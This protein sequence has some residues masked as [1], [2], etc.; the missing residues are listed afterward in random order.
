MRLTAGAVSGRPGDTARLR[1]LVC[2]IVHHPEDARILYRQIRAILDA[3]HSV[4]YAAPF[5]AYDIDPWPELQA[6]DVPRAMGRSRGE[7]L[8]A[9]RGVLRTYGPEADL[10][11]LHD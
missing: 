7:A 10:I 2:T 9:A 4:T 3:G 5:S 8:R 1:V 11:L 6:I